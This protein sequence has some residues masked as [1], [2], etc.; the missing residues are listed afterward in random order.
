M[1]NP[2]LPVIIVWAP[3]AN[4]EPNSGMIYSSLNITSFIEWSYLVI[5]KFGPII[6]FGHLFNVFNLTSEM[7]TLQLMKITIFSSRTNTAF[8]KKPYASTPILLYLDMFWRW[9]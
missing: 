1:Y 2:S 5:A 7:L 8:G 4:P 3:A 9:C 6:L